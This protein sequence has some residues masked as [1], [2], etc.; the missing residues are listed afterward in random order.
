MNKVHFLDHELTVEMLS[1]GN[2]R[3]AIILN[4]ETGEEF[5]IATTNMPEVFL[6]DGEILIKNWS[7]NEGIYEAL[8]EAGIIGEAVGSV[9]AG[10]TRALRCPLLI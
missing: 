7:E 3:T 8:I 6:Q 5:V 10:M 2:G 4:D 9:P 1:Y